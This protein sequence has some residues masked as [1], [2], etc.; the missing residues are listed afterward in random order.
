MQCNI[1]GRCRLRE[2]VCAMVQYTKCGCSIAANIGDPPNVA[3]WQ[4][5]YQVP[6]FDKIWINSDTLPK[7]NQFTDRMLTTGFARDKQKILVDVI[8]YCKTFS[9]PGDP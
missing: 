9:N 8:A 4:A 6:Q 7:R 5:Y 1:S 3:G 2:P